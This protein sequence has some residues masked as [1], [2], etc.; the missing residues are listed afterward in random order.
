MLRKAREALAALRRKLTRRGGDRR[1]GGLTLDEVKN[2][3]VAKSDP[4]P[5]ATHWSGGG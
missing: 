2:D 1:A 4:T 5:P 3:A